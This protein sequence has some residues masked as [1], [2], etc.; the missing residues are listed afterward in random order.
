VRGL[1]KYVVLLSGGIDSP[2]A[3]HLMLER[4][5]ELVLLHFDNRPF[6]D[7]KEIDKVHSLIGRLRELHGDM[8]AYIAPHGETAQLASARAAP[9]RLGCVLCRRMMFGV[10]AR[11]AEREGAQGIVTGE[12]LGQVASQTLANIRAEQSAL[13]MLPAVRPLIGFDKE[14]IVRIGKQIGTYDLSTGPG[15]CCTIVPDKPSVAAR[16]SDVEGAE[17]ELEI[18]K[19]VGAAR[20]GLKAW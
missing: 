15:L 18:D 1:V 2:V 7:E 4:G 20:E 13:G 12:S 11:L 19:L 14:E 10:A 17:D 5:A 16:K 9:R 3:A 8:P 6:T